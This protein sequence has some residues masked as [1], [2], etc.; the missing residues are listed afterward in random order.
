MDE[1][2]A[3]AN[4]LKA[5]A[6]ELARWVWRNRRRVAAAAIVAVPIAARYLPGFPTDEAVAVLRS[7]LGA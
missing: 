7:F 5:K 2:T 6:V 3:P 4:G 1:N